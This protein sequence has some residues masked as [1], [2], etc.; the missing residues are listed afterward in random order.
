MKHPQPAVTPGNVHQIKRGHVGDMFV[1]V[2]NVNETQK[3]VNGDG[4]MYK[5][6]IEEL[7]SGQWLCQGM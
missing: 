2:Q 7:T 5:W 6:V 1:Q 4:D 3:Q